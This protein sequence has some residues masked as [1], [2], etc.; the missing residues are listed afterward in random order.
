MEDG[1]SLQQPSALDSREE[2]RLREAEQHGGGMLTEESV[3]PHHPKAVSGIL[4]IIKKN[5]K[6]KPVKE[7]AGCL[8]GLRKS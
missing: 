2:D 1:R 6:I 3:N 5:C 4:E 7:Y 8:E